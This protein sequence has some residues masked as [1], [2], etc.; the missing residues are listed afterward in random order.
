MLVVA[1]IVVWS[2]VKNKTYMLNHYIV[3][4]FK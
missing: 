2:M 4:I 3:K 1:D